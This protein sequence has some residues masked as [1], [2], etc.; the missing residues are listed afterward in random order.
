MEMIYLIP[1]IICSVLVG[2]FA[3]GIIRY[4]VSIW[5]AKR[6]IKKWLDTHPRRHKKKFVYI[7]KSKRSHD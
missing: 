5:S 7:P 3:G 1:I 2:F 6:R 4:E